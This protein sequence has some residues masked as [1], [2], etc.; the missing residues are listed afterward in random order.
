MKYLVK[1][2]KKFDFKQ[3]LIPEGTE[4]MMTPKDYEYYKSKVK[5]L[6][7][8]IEFPNELSIIK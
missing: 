3:I 8:I 4:L 2:I 6:K 1:V 5:L 7:K